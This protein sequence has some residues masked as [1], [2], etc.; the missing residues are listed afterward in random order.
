MVK[1]SFRPSFLLFLLLLFVAIHCATYSK[2]TYS[3]YE[4]EN[5]VRLNA[6]NHEGLSELTKQ[7]LKSNDLYESYS[8][9]PRLVI[10]DLDN[11]LTATKSRNLAYYLAELCYHS[12]T[13]LD[14]EDPMFSRMFASALV[15]SYT[16]L[17]DSNAEPSEPD[18]FAME[19]RFAL[20]T[21]NRSLA[22]LVRFAKRNRKL[23][24]VTD[25]NVHLVRGTLTMTDVKVETAWTPKSFLQV[26]V[27]WDYK[28]SGF[29][30][31]I[32]REGI[33]APLILVRKYPELEPAERR[34]YEFVGGVGQ[35][36]PGTAFLSLEESYLENRSLELKATI[37]LYDPVY[38]NR[39]EFSGLDLP[40]ES[41]T[42]TPLAYMLSAAQKK[43]GFLSAFDGEA[44]REKRGLYFVYPYRHDKIPVVFV[45]GLASS[46]FVWFPMINELLADPEIN[47][48]YQFWV[49]WYPT[50]NPIP[51]SGAEFRE[52][53][54]DLRKVYDPKSEH[55]AF[56]KMVLVGHSMGGILAKLMVIRSRKEEWLRELK[57]VP[58]VWTAAPTDLKK[59]VARLFDYDPV[60]FVRRVIFIATP[61]RGSSLAEGFLGTVARLLFVLPKGVA[62]NLGKAVRFLTMDKN[63]DD[64]VSEKYGVD[65]LSPQSVFMKVTAEKIP[66]VKFH[67]II[68]NSRLRDLDWINDSVVSY[69]S[70]HLDGAESELLVP[71]EH[72]VQSH[73]PT[74]LE[75]KRILKEY[76]GPE[77]KN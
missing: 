28:V 73:I 53:L 23:A 39:I 47:G 26:E 45:H 65:S 44:G 16:Y 71:S 25:L 27:A 66:A 31:H 41:D 13:S 9:Y 7:F 64:F 40:M 70:S 74:F 5:L 75:V 24:R 12:G 10:Y 52:T 77:S 55:A 48:K 22:Q 15:Y 14:P 20:D 56:D 17:F 69:D 2:K 50:S 33:G 59:Q 32:R 42:T 49:Y 34:K 46:P 8:E 51:V 62:D 67:S 76:G 21:Y 72:S 63:Q 36:Y 19:F 60:H 57:V 38:R 6:V 68:G 43:D 11:R 30:N 37:H 3:K 4:Q 29:S 1:R 58:A 61:H 54:Y 35:A 18:P